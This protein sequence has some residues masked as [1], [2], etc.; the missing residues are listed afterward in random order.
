MGKYGGEQRGTFTPGLSF[1]GASVGM[2]FST[3]VGRY[4]RIG[5][6]VWFDINITLSAKGTS[7]GNA[8]VTGLP[9]TSVNASPSVAAP[10]GYATALAASATTALVA[11]ININATTIQ[12]HRFTAGAS[13]QIT[14][15]DF[16]N[17][18]D[19]YV[20]GLFEAAA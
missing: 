7:V 18:S 13:V 11:I 17:T 8:L 4:I 14:D 12:I 15:A 19:F 2:T 3:Q 10:V 6:L 16:G 5:S 1:G 9:F 20:S